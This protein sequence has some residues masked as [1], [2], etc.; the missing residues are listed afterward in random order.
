MKRKI[1]MYLNINQEAAR[2]S[3]CSPCTI[4]WS[5]RALQTF[6][7]C[8][9]HWFRALSTAERG[10]RQKRR[11]RRCSSSEMNWFQ[12]YIERR[13]D[14]ASSIAKKKRNKK[15][16]FVIEIVRI[17]SDS[18]RSG[19]GW[20][21]WAVLQRVRAVIISAAR[22]MFIQGYKLKTF[23]RAPFGYFHAIKTPQLR[24]QLM[25]NNQDK[26]TANVSVI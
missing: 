21:S 1:K 6:E 17:E 2:I 22:I 19:G 10:P 23:Q 11:H 4:V 13:M 16:S 9:L 25:E 12:W 26:K 3:N 5:A 24:E 15:L 20:E 18:S 14:F 7:R 8:F